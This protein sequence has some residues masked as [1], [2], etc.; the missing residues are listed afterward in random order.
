MIKH[1][2][3]LVINEKIAARRAAGHEVVHL[4][5]GEAGLPVL[6]SVAHA[7]REAADQNSYGPVR[8][9]LGARRAAAGYFDRRGVPASPDRVIL[10]PGSKA[11]LYG[12]LASLPGDVVLP[13]PSWVTYAA[14]A[15]LTGKRT[16]P[17]PIPAEAG[18]VPDPQRLEAA[19]HT[20]RVAGADPR[21]LILTLPDNPT[22]TAA[23]ADLVKQVTEI[24]AREDLV[25][26]S[27][28]I[29]QDLTHQPDHHL[30]PAAL[31]P[32]RTMVTA[33]L[34]KNMALGGW[35]IGFARLPEGRLGAHLADHLVGVASEVWTS[36]AMPMQA[37]A[38]YVLSEPEEVT[39]HISRSR[40]LHASVATAVH[41]AFIDAGATCRT[42]NAAFYMYPDFEPLRPA[43]EARAVS[44]GEELADMLLDEDN[45]AVLPGV[46]FGDDPGA[47]RFRVASSL[48]YGTTDEQRWQALE[49][50]DPA[51]L[52]WIAAAIERLRAV[53]TKLS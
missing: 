51:A 3:T 18:G 16:I 4:G 6:P 20:A 7:L 46:H 21:I 27:D 47:Y 35:R 19:L 28:E 31:A 36:L 33:G 11:L 25:I 49:A 23:E 24:A 30:S 53:L 9:A 2:A 34:S 40:R 5:F 22:G 8:G 13:A 41:S 45:V 39:L 42:P 37:A 10:A 14:Q 12:A 48:L 52:P 29:Y 1:S 38:A 32:G 44:T 50:D 17:V 15:T 26:V 43:L